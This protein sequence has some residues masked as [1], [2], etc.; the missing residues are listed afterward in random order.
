VKPEYIPNL[1]CVGR[2]L[3]VPP[4]V[5]LLAHAQYRVAVALFLVAGASDAL[6]GFLAKRFG[7]RTQLGGLL[8]PAADK[9][10]L[11]SVFLTLGFVRVVPP[12]LVAIVVARDLLIVA[13][14]LAYRVL[15]G[16]FSWR[17]R[18]I[19]KVNTAAQ[20]AFVL[21]ALLRAAFDVPSAAV[22][23]LLGAAVVA[24][25]ILS[26]ADYVWSWGRRAWQQRQGQTA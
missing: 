24:T 22:L 11:S 12:W 9:L 7:W 1:L 2:M 15:I 19:S 25:T 26:G 18:P 20:L 5:W 21:A 10:L 4:L 6:D 13:G 3:L 17:A 23:Q 14:A 16:R 8:D